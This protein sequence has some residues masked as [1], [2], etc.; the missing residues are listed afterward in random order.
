MAA[1]FAARGGA[2]TL[3]LERTSEGGRKLL[4]SGGGR[5]NILPSEV[6]ESRFVTDS[7]ANSMKKI[8]R[9]WPLSEQIDFFEKDLRLPLEKEAETGKLFPASQR[10]RDVRD[11]MLSDAQAHGAKLYSH[12]FVT[13]L[14]P[15]EHG[16]RV[17]LA[18]APALE[19][20]RVVI[21]TGGL[22][23]PK[24]GSDGSG[25]A[26]ARK[27][28]LKV[29]ITYAALTPVT[30]NDR[31]FHALAGIALPVEISAS[32]SQRSYSARDAFLFTHRGFSGPAVLDVSHILVRSQDEGRRDARMYVNWTS[33]DEEE[34]TRRL[35]HARSG[36]VLGVLRR[37]LPERLAE[38][39]CVHAQVD[40]ARTLS[41]LRKDERRRLLDALLRCDLPWSGHEGYRVAEVT[42]GG[43]D[44]A[45][46][47]PKTMECRK[48]PGLH[49]CGEVLDV[50][51]P[52]GGYNF[53]WAWATGRAAGIGA[54]ECV[55]QRHQVTKARD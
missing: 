47:H 10:A 25:F 41:Q 38:A 34:W 24:T 39:L 46:V 17:Q 21:A 20:N 7:S 6:D 45:E 9:S 19:V 8:L 40:P 31:R 27:L 26:F 32:D 28:G 42:G 44:L 23:V 2:E 30:S 29:N 48:H 43:V 52:I 50:F 33:L 16:W 5:C 13:G 55:A 35:D 14:E 12:A 49:F 36:T 22:S 11:A 53:L 3:L 15:Q 4:I 54:M 1:V 18:N 37:E 51:G